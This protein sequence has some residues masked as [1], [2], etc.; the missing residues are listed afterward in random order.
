MISFILLEA[1]A[2]SS[3]VDGWMMAIIMIYDDV[4]ICIIIATA[5]ILSVIMVYD[6]NFSQ[7]T[8]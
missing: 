1:L 4:V 3:E 5:I 2:L 8:C 6:I 7:M